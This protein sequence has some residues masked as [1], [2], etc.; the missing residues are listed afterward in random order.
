MQPG[1]CLP[2]PAPPQGGQSSPFGQRGAQGKALFSRA[3]NKQHWE[4]SGSIHRSIVE[5]HWVSEDL[6]PHFGS[7]LAVCSSKGGAGGHPGAP[8]PPTKAWE[9]PHER[10]EEKLVDT[11]LSKYQ[12]KGH[13]K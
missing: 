13:W 6:S 11:A 2:L 10:T 9:S 8:P 1:D 4:A 12:E 5:K 3:F 7:A